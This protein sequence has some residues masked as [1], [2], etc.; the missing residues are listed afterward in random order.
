MYFTQKEPN[1]YYRGNIV[2][3]GDNFTGNLSDYLNELEGYK[4][5]F[6]SETYNRTIGTLPST[7]ENIM[8]DNNSIFDQP[9]DNLRPG[10]KT[11]KFGCK[12]S[13]NLDNLPDGIESIEFSEFSE[14]NKPLDNL[15]TSLKKIT[16]GKFFNTPCNNLPRNLECLQLLSKSYSLELKNLPPGLR[17]LYFYDDNDFIYSKEIIGLPDKLIEIRYPYKYDYEIKNLPESVKIVR[18]SSCYKYSDEFRNNFPN[19]K[20][21]IY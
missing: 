15:P 6:I 20:L 7:I 19:K 10:I 9:I 1:F 11:I 18:V 4:T 16:F 17:Y 5:I 8:F 21:Y 14:F 13:Q 3:M 12:F 2:Y